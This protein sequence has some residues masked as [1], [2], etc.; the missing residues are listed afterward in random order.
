MIGKAPRIVTLTLATTTGPLSVNRAVRSFARRGFCFWWAGATLLM[1]VAFSSAAAET[2]LVLGD[3]L[4]SAYR[5]EVR[6]GWVHLLERRLDADGG[7]RY[8]VVNLSVT[9]ETTRGGRARLPAALREHTPDLVILELG[10]NDGLRGFP[11]QQTEDNLDAMIVESKAA[12]SD[13]LLLGMRL[14][15]NY[16]FRYTRAFANIYETLASRHGIF[17]VPFF[18]EG[19]ASDAGFMRSDGVHP[20]ESAQPVLL[21]NVW[22]VFGVWMQSEAQRRRGAGEH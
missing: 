6:Q 8:R 1:S 12:G 9:G 4:S 5:M 11:L 18:L 22:P 16:G 10:G 19:V 14:P 15:P 2:I 20:K 13:I 7:S 21:D 17:F 3:S